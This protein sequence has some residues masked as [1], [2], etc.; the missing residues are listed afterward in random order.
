MISQVDRFLSLSLSNKWAHLPEVHRGTY[1]KKPIAVPKLQRHAH[2]QTLRREMRIH[3]PTR[4]HL[5]L[6]VLSEF[7]FPLETLLCFS[8]PLVHGSGT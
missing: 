5:P 2:L 6:H 4:T 1:I 3:L 7:F 8:F